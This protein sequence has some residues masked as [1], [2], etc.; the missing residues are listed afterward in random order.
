MTKVS[1]FTLGCRANQAETA[2]LQGVFKRKGFLLVDDKKPSD[3]VVINSCTV[4]A[5]GDRE[6]RRIIARCARIN[7]G[8][9]VAVVGC[10]AQVKKEKVLAWP[11]VA[12]VVG[13]ARKMMLADIIRED[14]AENSPRLVMAPIYRKPFVMPST[15]EAGG[16]VRASLKIQDGC[17]NFCAYCEVPFAR[18]LPRSRIFDDIIKAARGFAALGRREIILT[19]INTGL[20]AHDGKRLADVILAL[21]DIRGVE[22]IRLSSVEFAPWLFS[23]A[24]L[25]KPPHKLCRFLHM[26]VQNGCDRI[27]KR[28]G[29]K[30]TVN[31]VASMARAFDENVPGMMIGTDIMAGFPG[32]TLKDF[33][34]SMAFFKQEPFDSF[35][36]FSY[37][38]RE[39]ARSRLFKGH[40]PSGEI[41][42]RADLLRILGNVKHRAFM[43]GMIGETVKVLFE[44]KKG[45]NCNHKCDRKNLKELHRSE[46]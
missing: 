26:P 36:V 38:D 14:A 9:R 21:E 23:L 15:P 33:E 19:G 40:V 11:H 34:Q 25:M 18:G 7:P 44:Q 6:T 35:H 13:N 16:R 12:W 4:T 31:D 3:I 45:E 46:K 24:S 1:F 5:Q 43:E 39:R 29:R 28:M 27:L 22:R 41:Q 17:D 8:V 10:L 30:Y 32:E 20:Y 42:R 2:V 37:S